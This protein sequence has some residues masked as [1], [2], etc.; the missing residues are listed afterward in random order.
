MG[1][2]KRKY[3]NGLFFIIGKTITIKNKKQING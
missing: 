2:N 1:I 3:R